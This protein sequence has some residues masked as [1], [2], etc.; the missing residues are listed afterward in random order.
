[1]KQVYDAASSDSPA[2][3]E[4][5]SSKP[6]PINAKLGLRASTIQKAVERAYRKSF[7]RA[8]RPLRRLLRNQGA[9]NDSVIEALFDLS[10]QTQEMIEEIAALQARLNVLE[11]HMNELRSKAS[12][13][14]P[15]SERD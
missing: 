12:G 11:T 15:R 2:A 13:P 6:L 7:V 9:V 14:R 3:G 10:A 5:A 8:V 4:D 1:M